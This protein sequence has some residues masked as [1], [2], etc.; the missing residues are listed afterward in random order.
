MNTQTEAD[1]V[2][3]WQRVTSMA[4]MN[5]MRVVPDETAKTFTVLTDDLKTI[6]MQGLPTLYF[7]KIY[8]EGYANGVSYGK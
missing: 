5:G 3:L 1:A 8:L 7:V 6:R 2:A 4:G